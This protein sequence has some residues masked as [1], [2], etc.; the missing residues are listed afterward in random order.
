MKCLN[1]YI[2]HDKTLDSFIWNINERETLKNK[3]SEN[4]HK[5]KCRISPNKHWQFDV[6][7]DDGCLFWSWKITIVYMLNVFKTKQ[8]DQKR[9][10]AKNQNKN[11]SFDTIVIGTQVSALNHD[12]FVCE[13]WIYYYCLDQYLLIGRKT[14]PDTITIIIHA[15]IDSHSFWWLFRFFFRSLHHTWHFVYIEH[16]Q[17]AFLLLLLHS[18]TTIVHMSVWVHVRSETKFRYRIFLIPSNSF[19]GYFLFLD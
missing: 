13:N 11:H 1:I 4:K 15:C 14:K 7:A 2:V 3:N 8:N 19:D 17:C 5:S 6:E 16:Y 9:K 10:Y 18:S 12:R